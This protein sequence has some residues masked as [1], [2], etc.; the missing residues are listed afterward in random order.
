MQVEVFRRL[1]EEVGLGW[2]YGITKNPTVEK[3][4]DVVYDFWAKY[5]LPLTGRSN[6]TDVI[7][8]RRTEGQNCKGARSEG[9][10]SPSSQ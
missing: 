5:R 1:Y 10:K 9:Q 7:E 2:I 3:V 4:A 8:N 6:L